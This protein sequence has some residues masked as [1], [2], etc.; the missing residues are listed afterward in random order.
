MKRHLGWS[1]RRPVREAAACI[2]TRLSD[3]ARCLRDGILLK[4][5]HMVDYPVPG[6]DDLT[7]LANP[8]RAADC[9]ACSELIEP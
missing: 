1:P 7:V 2:V 6:K 9:V 8:E 5:G 3:P 4:C